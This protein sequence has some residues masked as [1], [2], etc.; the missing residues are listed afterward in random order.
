MPTVLHVTAHLGGGVGRILS[1]VSI[2]AGIHSPY[3][4][5]ILCLEATRTKQFDELL[6]KHEVALHHAGS[7]DVDRLLKQADIVQLDWWHHPLMSEFMMGP[8]AQVSC[9]LIVWS[10]ISGCSFPHIPFDLVKYADRF[11]FSTPYSLEN[12]RWT[13]S[14]RMEIE[15]LTRTIVSSGI[16]TVDKVNSRMHQTDTDQFRVGYVGFLGYEKIHP[17]FIKYCESISDLPNISFVFAGDP[18]YGEEF[19]REM[20]ASPAIASK[21]TFLGYVNDVYELFRDIDVFVYLLNPEHYG[22]AENVLL[23]AMNAGVPPIVMNQC[24]EKYIVEDQITGVCVD[25]KESF[26][27]Q[28]RELYYD[29]NKLQTLGREAAARVQGRYHISR[30][31]KQL[32]EVYSDILKAPQ[33]KHDAAAVL[34]NTPF[35]WFRACYAGDL[36]N[37]KGVAFSTTKGSIKHYA[38]YYK[39][40]DRLKE[41]IDQNESRD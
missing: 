9:R 24:T 20:E 36:E 29:R 32:D 30:T 25:S 22:T 19:L 37:I 2:Y 16:D 26:R 5:E 15:L 38:S 14:Q 18:A 7:C 40:D 17:E 21:T 12:A 3:K 35:D 27:E 41:V 6:V 4:H 13:S 11:V 34:G 10:H 23:E 39:Y 33:R 1:S 31:V 28:M 8:L